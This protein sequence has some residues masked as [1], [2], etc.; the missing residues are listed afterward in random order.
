MINIKQQCLCA[1]VDHYYQPHI[2]LR[3][4]VILKKLMFD[5]NLTI[6]VYR[7]ERGSFFYLDFFKYF[8]SE[9]EQNST[10][11]VN[12][13]RKSVEYMLKTC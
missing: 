9:C 10:N 5:T 7:G 12:N 1:N 4:T 3:K 6:G 8:F 2:L 11:I 13:F